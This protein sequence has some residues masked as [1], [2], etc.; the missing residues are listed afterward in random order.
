MDGAAEEASS[1][2]QVR[3]CSKGLLEEVAEEASKAWAAEC[4]RVT[5][6]RGWTRIPL[7]T[8]GPGCNNAVSSVETLLVAR[9]SRGED[10]VGVI[11]LGWGLFRAL[12][13][14]VDGTSWALL[15]L[16]EGIG[17]RTGLFVWRLLGMR[18][19]ILGEYGA[20]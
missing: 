17:S 8:I 11:R 12:A 5:S 6:V 9:C 7:A 13:T 14:G 1:S 3:E 20:G 18:A 15:C 19:G 2:N 16:A 10:G 4:S